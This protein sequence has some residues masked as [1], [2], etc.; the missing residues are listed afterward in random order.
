MSRSRSLSK[1]AQAYLHVWRALRS[2]RKYFEAMAETHNQSRQ[3]RNLGRKTLRG[4]HFVAV[5]PPLLSRGTESTFGGGL[6]IH[7]VWALQH[8]LHLDF[9]VSLTCHISLP[10]YQISIGLVFLCDHGLRLS[11][12]PLLQ[13]NFMIEWGWTAQKAKDRRK[14][15]LSCCFGF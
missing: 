15:M 4:W 7:R 5:D 6:Q 10:H 9:M 3:R 14:S 2:K 13:R 8:R 1:G 11:L 12:P